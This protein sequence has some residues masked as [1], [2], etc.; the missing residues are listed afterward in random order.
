MIK[1]PKFPTILLTI[2]VWVL[3]VLIGTK[4]KTPN[5]IRINNLTAIMCVIG[6][7]VW[8]RCVSSRMI[9]L[10]HYHFFILHH[11]HIYPILLPT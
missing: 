10:R 6:P 9:A 2:H 7:V 3:F 11:S 1:V 8:D 5:K 4:K